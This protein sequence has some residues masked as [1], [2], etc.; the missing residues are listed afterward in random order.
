MSAI[1][2]LLLNAM[3]NAVALSC[4]WTQIE[5]MVQYCLYSAHDTQLQRR[6]AL[7]LVEHYRPAAHKLWAAHGL[8]IELLEE[9]RALPGGFHLLVMPLLTSDKGWLPGNKVCNKARRA[10][11]GAAVGGGRKR[12]HALRNDS[13]R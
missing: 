1:M 8:A 2:S 11:A 12:A 10:A 6:V 4:R 5:Q 7:K 9:P 3:L 13:G